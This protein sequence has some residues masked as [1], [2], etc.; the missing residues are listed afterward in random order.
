MEEI[1]VEIKLSSKPNLKATAVIGFGDFTVKGFRLSVSEHKN[2]NL[3]GEE[4]WLQPPSLRFGRGWQV[5]FFVEDKEIWKKIERAVFDK[6]QE[7]N[8]K[9]EIN[10]DD[11]WPK[12]T[13]Q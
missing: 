9:I 11:I 12:E 2:D 1:N 4:L 7:H 13:I 3:D 5:I 6:Y 8:K 10:G